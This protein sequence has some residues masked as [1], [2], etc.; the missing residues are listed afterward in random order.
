MRSPLFAHACACALDFASPMETCGRRNS[1]TGARGKLSNETSSAGLKRG[2]APHRTQMCYRYAAAPC[3]MLRG[4][5]V[6]WRRARLRYRAAGHRD[7]RVLGLARESG[8]EPGT[9]LVAMCRRAWECNGTVEERGRST[10]TAVSGAAG[11]VRFSAVAV[12]WES[13]RRAKASLPLF[14]ARLGSA[15]LGSAR[16]E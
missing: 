16:L 5:Y 13:V 1:P 3:C 2:W 12:R 15:R 4:I 8:G 14:A 6:V 9:R 11:V 10:A 7:V